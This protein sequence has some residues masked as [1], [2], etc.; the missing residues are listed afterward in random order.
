M[1]LQNKIKDELNKNIFEV[2][3]IGEM[4][5]GEQEEAI[6]GIGE[7]IFKSVL[8]RVLPILKEEELKEYEKLLEKNPEPDEVLEFFFEKIPNF[9]QVVAEETEKLKKEYEETK[10]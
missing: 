6:I 1:T 7:V 2:F 8:L 10:K 3:G 9:L 4:S 5:E